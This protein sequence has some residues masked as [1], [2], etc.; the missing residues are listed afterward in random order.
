MRELVNEMT[1][2]EPEGRPTIEAVVERFTLVQ[3]SLRR[4]K[5]RAAITHRK[6]PRLLARYIRTMIHRLRYNL[7]RRPSLQDP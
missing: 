2:A 3:H 4:S 6:D 7:H 5:L 1:A